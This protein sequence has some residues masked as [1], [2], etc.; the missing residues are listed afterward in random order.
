LCRQRPHTAVSPEPDGAQLGVIPYKAAEQASQI[1]GDVNNLEGAIIHQAGELLSLEQDVIVP[2]IA[3]ARLQRQRT[4]LPRIEKRDDPP[5]PTLHEGKRP[6][7][8]GLDTILK[9]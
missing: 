5:G 4:K 8:P 9:D 7:R 1:D 3:K 6:F 2:H